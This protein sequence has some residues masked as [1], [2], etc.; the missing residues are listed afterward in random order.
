MRDFKQKKKIQKRVYSKGVL[1]ILAISTV[2]LGNAVWNVYQKY[3][4]A[5]EKTAIAKTQLKKLEERELQLSASLASLKTSQGVEKELREKFGVVKDGE[6]MIL[7]IDAEK[8][9][10]N[11]PVGSGN[12]VSRAWRAVLDFFLH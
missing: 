8:N 11:T 5:A 10:Q 3:M 12:A 7:I 4:E 6:E 9:G 2:F 1:I